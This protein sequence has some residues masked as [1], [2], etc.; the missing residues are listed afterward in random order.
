MV[1]EKYISPN[2]MIMTKE[3]NVR[4]VMLTLLVSL[5][6]IDGNILEL[7]ILICLI[8]WCLTEGRENFYFNKD[9]AHVMSC[10]LISP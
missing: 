7:S 10:L 3:Y 6:F 8:Q 9:R 2:Y 5:I 1:P 4:Q